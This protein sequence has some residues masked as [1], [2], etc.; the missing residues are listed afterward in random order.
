MIQAIRRGL[1]LLVIGVAASTPPAPAFGQG[2]RS[3]TP[4]KWEY[5]VLT[6]ERVAALGKSDLA[7]GLNRLGEEG[8]QLVAVEPAFTPEKSSKDPA[9]AAHFFLM[10]PKGQQ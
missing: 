9:R 10:R 2:A 7:A 6:R 8:W 5:R 3:A 4:A 1:A